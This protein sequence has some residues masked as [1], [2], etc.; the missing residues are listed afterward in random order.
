MMIFSHD[1]FH[2]IFLLCE[3]LHNTVLIVDKHFVYLRLIQKVFIYFVTT[4][5][6]YYL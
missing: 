1:I 3:K 6:N 5:T 2:D 4:V